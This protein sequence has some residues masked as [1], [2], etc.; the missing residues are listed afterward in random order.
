M[1]FSVSANTFAYVAMLGWPAVC[2]ML[3]VMLPLETAAIAAMLGGYLLL[4]SNLKL[5]VP[6]LPPIDKM[7]VAS[8]STFVFCW[9][10]GAQSPGGRPS[11]VAMFFAAA[12]VV[13]P[14]MT[15]LDNSYELQTARGS[16]P[17]FYPIDGLKVAGRQFI[18]LLPLFVGMRFLS[19]DTARSK[20][21]KSLP[22]ALAFYSLPMLFEIRFSPQIHRWVYGYHPSDFLQQV[23]GGGFRPVVFLEHGLVVALFTSLALIAAMALVRQKQRILGLPAP[24]IATYLTGL[25]LLCKSLGA[26]IYAAVFAPII[27]F[28]RPRT[29]AKLSFL[30]VLMVCIYPV[31]RANN[32]SPIEQIS[33]AASTVSIDRSKSFQTRVD[34]EDLLLKKADEKPFFGWG[35]WGR[36]RV[37]DPETGKDISITDGQWIIQFGTYGWFGYI[38]FFGLLAS[39]VFGAYRQIGRKVTPATISLGA[40]TLL[41]GIYVI[42][43]IPNANS[44]ALTL[45]LAGSIATSARARASAGVRRPTAPAVSVPEAV[46]Q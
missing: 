7:G 5:D 24:V 17:G 35:T 6:L 25:L 10:K 20:L 32:L 8:L 41:L 2:L 19:T 39:A 43:M 30:L 34:N 33:N 37:Y 40:L 42:D 13:S 18:S 22:V 46:P 36:N 11:L 9:M 38:A 1:D 4:P 15:S 26:V 29:W 45:L 27:L 21:L 3:F 31:L 16:I 28:S 44:M 23:R 12:L 14:L